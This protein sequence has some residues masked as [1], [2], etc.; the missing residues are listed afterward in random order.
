MWN[1]HV[2]KSEEKKKKLQIRKVII[3]REKI[4]TAINI[5]ISFTSLIYVTGTRNACTYY[6]K[7][8]FALNANLIDNKHSMDVSDICNFFPVFFE[9]LFFYGIF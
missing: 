3:K 1:V 5:D 7:K 6:Y 4:F 8:L 2:L 9:L